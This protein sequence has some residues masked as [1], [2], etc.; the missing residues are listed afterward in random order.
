VRSLI[1]GN[2]EQGGEIESIAGDTPTIALYSTYVSRNLFASRI[3]TMDIE[4]DVVNEL[5]KESFAQAPTFTPDAKSI[6]YMTGAGAVIFP[7]QLQGAEGWIMN[8]DGSDK[9]RLTF[10]NM[11]GHAES[12]GRF[13][14][15]GSLSFVSATAFFGDVMKRSLGLVGKI[16][17]VECR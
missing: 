14:L 8:V 6:V 7:W 11:R 2:V 13:R 9:R 4:S 1:P 3:D 5:T 15:A 17:R 10:M 16:V 12:V